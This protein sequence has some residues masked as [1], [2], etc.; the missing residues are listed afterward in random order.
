MLA[1]SIP[2]ILFIKVAAWFT[3]P[4]TDSCPSFYRLLYLTFGPSRIQIKTSLIIGVQSLLENIYQRGA[5]NFPVIIGCMVK[6]SFA[7]VEFI[8]ACL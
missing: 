4:Q 5:Y 2:I 8:F 7:N 3:G 6:L 1:L